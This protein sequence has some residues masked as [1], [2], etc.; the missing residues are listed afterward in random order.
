[1]RLTSIHPRH[2][3]EIRGVLFQLET[4]SRTCDWVI[5]VKKNSGTLLS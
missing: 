1:M 2:G 3:L 4:G 5:G